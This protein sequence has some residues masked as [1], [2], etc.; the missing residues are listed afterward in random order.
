MPEARERE[1]V[2][3]NEALFRGILMSTDV[4]RERFEVAG[5]A[6]EALVAELSSQD[7]DTILTKF[8][9]AG[10]NKPIQRELEFARGSG[11]Y[12]PGIDE[13]LLIAPQLS[14]PGADR[15]WRVGDDEFSIK[16]RARVGS[17]VGVFTEPNHKA[18]G[19]VV[20]S[21]SAVPGSSDALEA[22]RGPRRGVLLFYPVTHHPQQ[23]PANDIPTMGFALLF[24]TNT[25]S[26]TIVFG[27]ADPARPTEPVVDAPQ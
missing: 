21:P 19:A 5:R 9:W 11:Q 20:I 13:W 1:K 4:R 25:I 10:A 17:R 6:F 2:V 7:V 23:R 26:S 22:L 8:K 27:V 3:A 18:A 14:T 15:M 12:D 24:P 16:Y